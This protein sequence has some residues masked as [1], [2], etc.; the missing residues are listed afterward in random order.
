V[1]SNFINKT[2]PHKKQTPK[3]VKRRVVMKKRGRSIT[4]RIL[5]I[6]S[7][8][9]I[10]IVS[11]I[12]I[13]V[14]FTMTN[15]TDSVMLDVMHTTAGTA[16]QN[17]SETLNHIAERLY[18]TRQ[19]STITSAVATDEEM[20]EFIETMLASMDFNWLGLYSVQGQVLS[21]SSESPENIA[22]H[23]IFPQLYTSNDLSIDNTSSENGDLDI[24]IGLPIHREW[25]VSIYLVGSYRYDILSEALRNI[26]IGDNC[27]AFIFDEDE[28][29]IAHNTATETIAT[30]NYISENLGSDIYI[31]QVVSLMQSNQDGSQV[32]TSAGVSMYTSHVPI[33]GTH[34]SF[35]IIT[36]R[37]D[38]TGGFIVAIMNSIILGIAALIISVIIFRLLLKRV[39]TNPLHRITKNANSMAL[40]KFDTDELKSISDRDDEI[41]ELGAGFV[42][43]SDSVHQVIS[44]ISILTQQASHGELG[45]RADADKY[46]GD[47]NLIMSGINSALDAFCSHLNAMPDAFALLNEN[48]DCI[49]RNASLS[50]LFIRHRSYNMNKAWLANLV[51][52]GKSKMLPQKVQ[53]FFKYGSD[54][55]EIYNADI[56]IAGDNENEKEISYYYSLTLKRVEIKQAIS[57]KANGFV[58]V[59]LL[60]T[61][62]T[63]L[64]NARIDAEDASRAKTEFLSIM[65]H[66]M[67]TPM[68]AIIGMTAIAQSTDDKE[69]KDYCLS[70]IDSA[71]A[72][73]LG[74]INNIL[75]M[76]KIEARKFELSNNDFN[77]RSMLQSVINVINFRIEEKE[78]D[79]SISIDNNIPKMLISDDLRLSQVLTN[80]LS[81]AVKFT[82]E[83][84]N[85]HLSVTLINE[86]KN[87]NCVI[88]FEVTDTGIGISEENQARLFN[89][90][91]QAESSISRKYGGTGLGL[92]IASSI[93]EI[94]GGHI[95]VRSET[96]K[97]STFSFTIKAKRGSDLNEELNETNEDGLKIGEDG[98]FKGQRVLLV[99]DVE[100]NRE[101]V[102]KMLENTELE[103]DC[104]ENGLLA[105]QYFLKNHEHYK[106]IIMD[107]QMPEMDG[108]TAT[109][110]IRALDFPKAKTIPIIAMTANVFLED[111]EEY[112]NAGMNDH[113][114]KPLDF[115]EL[116]N[117]LGKYLDTS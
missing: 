4:D 68:N 60:L 109:K 82:P 10:A 28:I 72:H 104:V 88:L 92:S 81:N 14:S 66:E 94:M 11:I 56:I 116:L 52:S 42:V 111:I 106:L 103:F 115:S 43:V 69:R 39:L 22:G 17:F 61:D 26:R 96:N 15:L 46:S 29:L 27:I 108:I 99:E 114:G 30:G 100:I 57:D 63:Q 1:S 70:R 93:I 7:L 95:W 89:S 75:D 18:L 8:M 45:T 76:S 5:I 97:G 110:K 102:V 49:F 65:S 48:G 50:N 34:W 53:D 32:I 98:C 33:Q 90:F 112:L 79:L 44:D 86:D 41:G 87:E 54:S 74:V 62:T 37:D 67:R 105:Y 38:F 59:M 107:I 83:G 77:F 78:H 64:N 21:G 25:L 3:K 2:A 47:F 113:L 12:L 35:G 73:L 80:L 55:D 36:F 19:D 58:C 31:E 6:S 91:E 16:A 85:I 84:G 24:I 117:T 51:T 20:S 40:G 23:S 9:L 71:S 101:I 13:F